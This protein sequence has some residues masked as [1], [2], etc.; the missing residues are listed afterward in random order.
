MGKYIKEFSNHTEYEEFVDQ[1][2]FDLQ[3]PNISLCN[4]QN[5]VHYS[6]YEKHDYSKNYLTFKALEGGTFSFSDNNIDYSLDDGKTWTTLTA[7][8]NTPLIKT[9]EK[10][11]WKANGLTPT[12]V[13]GIG[14]F[15]STGKFDVEGNAMSLLYGNNFE[16]QTDLTGKNSAFASLFKYNINIINAKNLVLPATV[17]SQSCYSGMFYECQNLVKG[18][19]TLPAITALTSCYQNM[20]YH[21]RKLIIT[22]DLPATT[23][24]YR[25][26]YQMFEDCSSLVKTSEL[27]I[28]T[29]TGS[30]DQCSR[31]FSGCTSLITGP[32]ILPAMTLS[33][34]CYEAMFGGCSNLIKA[35]VLPATQVQYQS[36]SS[37]F[38]GCTNL[39]S[40]TC[41]ATGLG[42]G[43]T[44]NW[45]SN[46]ASTGTFIKA[47]S[48][49]NWT[50]GV[51]GIPENWTVVDAS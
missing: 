38:S 29:F 25:S 24:G 10:I 5:E 47:A 35:P 18:P 7:S 31:M 37:M 23:V 28:T 19:L 26:Y 11:M 43:S 41:L 40:I 3:T 20:F 32:S 13:V 30:E 51:N 44:S 17:L 2:D 1:V 6:P 8:Q 42:Y 4:R 45:V 21:C 16:N 14:T 39:N 22:P 49:N 36:Y 27:P 33:A 15:S 48:M 50:T 34:E 9:G 46:V 12:G